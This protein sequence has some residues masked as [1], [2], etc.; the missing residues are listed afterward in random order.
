MPQRLVYL[1]T[2]FLITDPTTGGLVSVALTD[3][4]GR[5]YMA[6]NA[7]MDAYHVYNH[8]GMRESVWT[9]LPTLASMRHRLDYT[10]PDVKPLQQIADE[11]AAYFDTGEDT[12]LY[13]YY[14]AHH[15]FRL[16]SLWGHDREATPWQVPRWHVELRALQDEL[17]DTDLPEQDNRS[18]H[19]LDEARHI[20]HI[21]EHLL[22]LTGA[23]PTCG[24]R[25]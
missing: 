20:R 9:R 4:T 14:G 12:R 10:H 8:A 13:A 21:H 7:E 11:V 25:R 22:N 19:L 1:D 17:G 5:E 15:L 3:N 2:K 23:T 16:H 6:A 24:G 18:R